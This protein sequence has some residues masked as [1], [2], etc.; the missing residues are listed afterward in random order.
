[1]EKKKNII[2]LISGRGS[3]ML[4][5]AG[6]VKQGILQDACTIQAVFSNKAD[7]PGLVAAEQQGI[8]THCISSKGKKRRTYDTL[9]LDWLT[10]Q[11]PD[12]IVLAGY[13]R[14]LPAEIIRAFPH[15]IINIHP[16]D[17]ALHQ[18]LHGYEWAWKNRLASTCITVHFVDEG[19]DTGQ[20][21][22]K[23]T[24]DLQDASSLEEVESRGLAVEHSFYSICLKQVFAAHQRDRGEL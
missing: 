7:A 12:F 20:V 4:A 16:A 17:T 15:R 24:V 11:N 23:K 19:L 10:A 14:V 3:N 1:M 22:G 9:L 2:I 5:I 8:A 6:N 13:M 21:I 18:G